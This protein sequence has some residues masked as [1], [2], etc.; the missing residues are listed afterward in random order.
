MLR[1]AFNVGG[2][3]DNSLCHLGLEGE[4]GG[5]YCNESSTLFGPETECYGQLSILVVQ[6]M[7]SWYH[8]GLEGEQGGD[9]AMK[10]AFS[11]DL[12]PNAVVSSHCCFNDHI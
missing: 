10:A 3:N 12:K 8:L 2:I 11:L 1:S 5:I 6:M 4:H 7:D 9:I